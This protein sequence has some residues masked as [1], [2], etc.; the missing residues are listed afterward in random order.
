MALPLPAI[1]FS[2]VVFDSECITHGFKPV[3]DG[4]RL[5]PG[6]IALHSDSLNQHNSEFF[7]HLLSFCFLR[8]ATVLQD[9]IKH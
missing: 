2:A 9:L 6:F 4:G 1:K 8:F 3:V 5:K 7:H